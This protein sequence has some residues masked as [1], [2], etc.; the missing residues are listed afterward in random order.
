MVGSPPR[1]VQDHEPQQT[2]Q[3]KISN[4]AVCRRGGFFA[5]I[6]KS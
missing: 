2:G 5:I 4:A 3:F 6:L 1:K